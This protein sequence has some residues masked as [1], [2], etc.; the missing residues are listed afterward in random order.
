MKGIEGWCR[1]PRCFG[2]GEVHSYTEGMDPTE[3]YYR[4]GRCSGTGEV[5][6]QSEYDRLAARLL[7]L[8]ALRW[9]AIAAWVYA[10]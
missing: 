8:G 1:C 2:R 10:Q 5:T 9:L 4:C 3:S 7:V 6:D